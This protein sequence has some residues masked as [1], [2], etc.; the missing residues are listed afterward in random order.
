MPH[1]KKATR[2]KPSVTEAVAET[3]GMMFGKYY[4]SDFLHNAPD[5]TSLTPE[6]IEARAKHMR[7]VHRVKLT[8]NYDS[9]G[10]WP[11]DRGLAIPKDLTGKS[12]LDIGAWDGIFTFQAEEAKA[13]AVTAVDYCCWGGKEQNQPPKRGFED[14]SSDG[15]CCWGNGRT[16]KLAH[17]ARK[18]K[19]TAVRINAYD[20]TPARLPEGQYDVVLF[21]GVLYHLRY[22]FLALTRVASVTKDLLILETTMRQDTSYDPRKLIKFY[23]SNE[24][25]S[26]ITNWVDPNPAALRGMLDVLGFRVIREMPNALGDRIVLHAFKDPNS[27]LL[28]QS[29]A[30]VWLAHGSMSSFLTILVAVLCALAAAITRLVRSRACCVL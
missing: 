3:N 4:V 1:G 15:T 8:S 2:D 17:S 9:P 5:P 22:P 19:A 6:K 13:R 10:E 26:D 14:Q 20:L 23:S 7:W 12:F 18:S 25:N 24:L 21:S 28:A 27:T 11:K 30:E 16:F 29:P